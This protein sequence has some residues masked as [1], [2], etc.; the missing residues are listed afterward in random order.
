M[1]AST[2][3]KPHNQRAND[4]L[5]YLP[6]SDLAAKIRAKEISPVEAVDAVLA[7]IEALNPRL[8]AFC[9]VHADEARAQ[10][11]AAEAAV[12]RGDDDLGPLHG[13]PVSVKD[14]VSIAGKPLTYGSRL[15]QDNVASE[16]S[17]IGA[18]IATAG[19]IIVGRTNTPEYAWRGSTDNRLFGETRNPWD[20]SRTAGGSSGG[21]G[22]AVAAGLTPLSLGTDGAGSIRIPASFCGIVGHK[23]SF[24]RVP[25]FPSPGA[26]E[27]AAHAGPMTRTVRDAALFLDVLAGPDERDRF[28][29]PASGERYTAFVEGGVEGWRV[30]WSPDLGHIPV[31]PEVLQIAE[32]AAQAFLELGARLDR[33]DLGLPDPEPL[34]GTLYPFVQAAA[35]AG[36]MT[37]TVRDA[38][39]FLDVLAGPDERDR[40]S[41]PASDERYAAS[42][43]GGVEGWRIAW[44]P[45][46]GHIPVDPEVLQIAE[47]A[48]RAFLELGAHLDR[49]DLGLPDPEPLLG[50]L[51]PFVQAAAHAARPPEQH[52]EMDP[53]LVA[54]AQQGAQ[55]TA[56]QV[57]QAMTARA[58]YW[59]RMCR[60]LEQFDVLLTP[61]ISVPAFELGIVGPTEVNGRPVVHL[62]WTLAYPFNLT[63]QPAITVPCGFTASGLPVGLQI[64]GKR[65]AD[66]PVLRAAAAFEAARPWAA[67]R[68]AL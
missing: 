51:Y 54:I 12:L 49:P 30:A 45:D 57:G 40:F 47:T 16:T 36:P 62:A 27:L 18:R 32:S 55:L 64:L 59:D 21:A 39:L 53:G 17:P 4:A 23:P 26:N 61:T 33:P 38:A 34:L 1:T 67:H 5:C 3:D 63:G 58:A 56:V 10:A 14:N 60:A 41:L 68:P 22:A 6:A 11:R 52:A 8:N 20:L 66:G 50:T 2:D 43:E 48:A 28:S 42:V 31:D 13:V 7:H 29:L 37:R 46:L 44:S 65:Y 24:G 25:F 15:L 19:A 35:H 9:F